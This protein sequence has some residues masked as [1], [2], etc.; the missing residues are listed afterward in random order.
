MSRPD[1]ETLLRSPLDDEPEPTGWGSALAGFLGGVVVVLA[2]SWLLGV[3]PGTAAQTTAPD[4]STPPSSDAPIDVEPNRYP[5]GF[6]EVGDSIAMKPTGAVATD[7]GFVVSF[8]MAAARDADVDE[9]E[10]PIGG[11]W[12]IER[13]DGSIAR[14]NRLV[15]DAAHT[16]VIGVGFPGSL[17]GDETVRMVARW[18]PVSRDAEA[19]IPFTGTPFVAEGPVEIDVGAGLTLK[20]G[21]IELGRHL[22]RVEWSITGPGDPTA[23]VSIDV[24][25]LDAAGA[26]IGAYET[27]PSPRDPTRA[28]GVAKM[29]WGP[30]FDVHPDE[31]TT[32]RIIAVVTVA[33]RHAVDVVYDLPQAA[34]G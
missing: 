16:D 29:F 3:G 21:P 2:A 32:V 6:L 18:D 19:E 14:A 8:T 15:Y 26:P 17:R 33:D 27:Q 24:T 1:Y 13:G 25:L 10:R 11:T 23:A 31:A 5:P 28:N 20:V 12:Q 34:G 30:G 9:L 4:S 7:G 22:G